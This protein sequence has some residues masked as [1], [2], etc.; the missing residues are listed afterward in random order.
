MSIQHL[1]AAIYSLIRLEI[2]VPRYFNRAL[3]IVSNNLPFSVVSTFWM[4]VIIW[5][6]KIL[7]ALCSSNYI[8]CEIGGY[9]KTMM[10][11]FFPCFFLF[12]FCDT[13][14][15]HSFDIFSLFIPICAKSIGQEKKPDAINICFYAHRQKLL[16]RVVSTFKYKLLGLRS[17]VNANLIA[18]T[19]ILCFDFMPVWVNVFFS[20]IYASIR[21]P[22]I[23]VHIGNCLS[24]E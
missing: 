22:H 1:D 14:H 7:S 13:F 4:Y 5:Q 6:D 19:G 20:S 12:L 9:K 15:T 16:R 21:A 2:C 24:N 23:K 10:V 11:L 17:H 18:F 8:C 3:R